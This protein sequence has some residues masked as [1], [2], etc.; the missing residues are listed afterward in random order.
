PRLHVDAVGGDARLAGVAK[1]RTD[2]AFNGAIE[3]CVIEHDR[4]RAATELQRELL[5]VL[6][7]AGDELLADFRRSGERD[8]PAERVA[9]KL[10]ADHSGRTVDELEYAFGELGRVTALGECE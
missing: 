2:H 3:V 10:L 8:L 5:Q 4:R 6:R 1:L 7:G 9:Q